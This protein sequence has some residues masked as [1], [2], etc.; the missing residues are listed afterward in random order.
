MPINRTA[1]FTLIELMITVVILSVIV[2]IAYPA[3]TQWMVQTRRSDAQIAL[4]QAANQQERFFTECNWYA[5]N[6]G[7]SPR[8]C[9]TAATGDLNFPTTSPDGH[10][11][12]TMVATNTSYI[13]TATPTGLQAGNGAL[14]I[15][16]TGRRQWNRKNLGTWV[17]WTDK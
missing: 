16:S 17:K 12:L 3:Y 9:K 10:Y 2:S 15:D 5:T 11:N 8:A 4:T 14:R 7:G 6:I 13:I 1:G